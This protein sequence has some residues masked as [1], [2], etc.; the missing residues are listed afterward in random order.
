MKIG[1]MSDLHL[2]YR[3]YGSKER[4]QDY[5]DQFHRIINDMCL[6]D[7]IKYIICCGDIFDTHNP[8]NRALYEFEQGLN[9][10]T[11]YDKELIALHGNH[12]LAMSKGFQPPLTIF[13]NKYNL[14]LIDDNHVILDN[15]FIGGVQSKSATQKDELIKQMNILA[16]TAKSYEKS[17]LVL[18][19][20]LQEFMQFGADLEIKDLPKDFDLYLIGHLHNR[21]FKSSLLLKGSIYYPGSSEIHSFNEVKDYYKNGKGWSIVD[22]D[23]WSIEM[24]NISLNRDFYDMD[25]EYDNLSDEIIK[26]KNKIVNE[27]HKP[28]IRVHVIGENIDNSIVHEVV[29][30][31]LSSITLKAQIKITNI[32]TEI[33]DLNIENVDDLS[34]EFFITERT[35]HMS[36]KD[37]AFALALYRRTSDSKTDIIE[38]ADNYFNKREVSEDSI[39]KEMGKMKNKN[40]NE[41]FNF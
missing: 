34:P 19:Q 31:N 2:G 30:D 16:N 10:L 37:Q 25:F 9:L 3:Q 15:L 1:V 40:E 39:T 17:I 13:K 27:K 26:F 41:L 20:G 11:E 22:T 4:E 36:E 14:Q 7:D 6:R 24:N 21:Y 32:D 23:D 28:I 18:H 12:D 35:K 29:N 33:E 38:F 5:Y 8:S